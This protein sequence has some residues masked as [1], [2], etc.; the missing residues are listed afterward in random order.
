MG[1][2]VIWGEDDHM[3]RAK[4]L[5]TAYGTT[6]ASVK[7][8]PK[9]IGGLDKLVFW[10]HGDTS[11]FCT[12]TPAAFVDL[13]GEWRKK[14]PG[15]TTVEM[16]TCN[17]RHKQTNT[18]SY[19][20]QVVTA[21]SRKQAKMADKVKF[22]ALPVASTASGKTCDWSILKWH[23]GSA[24][25]AYVAA[26][27]R[28]ILNHEDNDMHDA[29]V[30]LE[31]FMKPRGTLDGYRQAFAAFSAFKGMTLQHPFAVKYKYDQA[32]VDA[33]NKKY[34]EVKDDAYIIAGTLGLLRWLLVDI[35]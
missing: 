11:H 10:G 32:K 17:A 1:T 16:L 4:S 15:L 3:V 30:M 5:A 7:D 14:N 13:V 35:K 33:F 24:T 20:D 12:L 9:T 28:Q 25:W 18:D 23:P 29:V 19:T 34:K 31:N 22:R 21:L 6:A 26:P 8:K 27:T 2:F